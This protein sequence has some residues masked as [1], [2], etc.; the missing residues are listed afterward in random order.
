M[1]HPSVRLPPPLTAPTTGDIALDAALAAIYRELQG[2]GSADFRPIRGR[3]ADLVACLVPDLFDLGQVVWDDDAV[4]GL[5]P[6]ERSRLKKAADLQ[7]SL[8]GLRKKWHAALLREVAGVP[9]GRA[10]LRRLLPELP[11]AT[12]RPV[13][14]QLI[15]DAS[16]DDLRA[17]A[18]AIPEDAEHPEGVF[19]AIARLTLDPGWGTRYFERAHGA[20]ESTLACALIAV[21][22]L[23]PPDV[24]PDPRWLAVALSVLRDPAHAQFGRAVAWRFP[25]D[26]A[27][28]EQLLR[29]PPAFEDH[30]AL[31]ARHDDP[32]VFARFVAYAAENSLGDTPILGALERSTHAEAAHAAF[33]LVQALETNHASGSRVKRFKAVA[34]ALGERFGVKAPKKAK[35]APPAP[36]PVATAPAPVHPALPPAA[37]LEADLRAAFHAAGLAPHFDALVSPAIALLATRADPATIPV[38]ATRLGGLPDLPVDAIWPVVKKTPLTFVG[39]VDLAGVAGTAAARLLPASGLLSFFVYDTNPDDYARKGAVLFTPAGVPLVRHAAPEAFAATGRSAAPACRVD[40]HPTWRLVHPSHRTVTHSLPFDAIQAFEALR[41][42][43]D[44]PLVSTLLGFRDRYDGEIK[45]G[46]RLLLQVTSDPQA[47]FQWGDVDELAFF[48]ADKALAAGQFGS[49]DVRVGD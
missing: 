32:R 35:V 26:E 41:P 12:R 22:R 16:P 42:D 10:G 11:K 47:D 3:G 40:L 49:V 18:S 19:G 13:L 8:E 7:Y 39:Q 6:A 28:L 2:E 4:D 14:Q 45:R 37:A 43:F 29:D 17:I 5:P 27:L 33:A 24:L 21:E 36:K 23:T 34:K 9:E 48:I 38:G 44:A 30:V 46:Y 1:L 15:T 31:L 25:A 20:S